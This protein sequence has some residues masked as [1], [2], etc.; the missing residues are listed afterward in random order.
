MTQ[1]IQVP[2]LDKEEIKKRANIFRKR[3]WGVILPVDIEKIIDSQLR[4]SIVPLP[5]LRKFC[6]IDAQIAFNL[7][8]I[9]VDA[10]LYTDKRQQ[11]RL[12]FSLA[13]EIGHYVLHKNIYQ[14]FKLKNI[15]QLRQAILEQIS[16]KQYSYLETQANKFA[17]YLLVPR[18]R[19][20]I[21]KSKLIMQLKNDP[22]FIKLTD[23]K[24]HASYLAIQLA[25]IF[26]VSSESME[27]ALN[28]D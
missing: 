13:H 3:W 26:G 27:I 8:F 11:N 7:R 2:F 20:L 12:R 24:L 18:D 21:E 10:D 9:Y 5:N 15:Y 19:L 4:I 23:N 17:S 28:E 25:N 1:I 6:D 14:N 16:E 22:D